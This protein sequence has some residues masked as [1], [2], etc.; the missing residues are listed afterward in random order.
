MH[1]SHILRCHWRDATTRDLRAYLRQGR[2][3]VEAFESVTQ[4]SGS[5]SQSWIKGA[6]V[7]K[8]EHYPPADV[9][10]PSSGAH[11]YF[12]AHRSHGEEH[13]HLHVFWHATATGRRSRFNQVKGKFVGSMPTHLI[14]IALDARGL[15]LK[16]FTTNQWVTGGHWFNAELTLS[17]IDRCR[18]QAVEGHEFSCIWLGHFLSMYRPLIARLLQKRDAKLAKFPSLE[19]ALNNRRLEVL[20][21]CTIDWAADLALL[22]ELAH[23]R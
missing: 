14:A 20:S 11:F 6:A 23:Q 12:H 10:D 4:A 18:P 5:L 7:V 3:S 16:L 22:E 13:G 8:Y 9:I 21:Q 2:R 17:C 19:N 15:P 1:A